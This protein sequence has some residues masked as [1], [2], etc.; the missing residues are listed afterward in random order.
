MIGWGDDTDMRARSVTT[1]YQQ[2]DLT[3][4]GLHFSYVAT[5]GDDC[6]GLNASGEL[7]G[8]GSN[9]YHNLGLPKK[10]SLTPTLVEIGVTLVSATAANVLVMKK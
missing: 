3:R 9:V 8:W 6:F 7:Y 5:G 4:T 2:N 10:A 1:R